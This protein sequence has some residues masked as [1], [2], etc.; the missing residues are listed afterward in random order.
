MQEFKIYGHQLLSSGILKI[1]HIGDSNEV[2]I[3][4]MPMPRG[5]G[6]CS[7]ISNIK[8]EGTP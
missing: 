8:K 6:K 4:L 1:V 3:V 7:K 2:M 5:Y